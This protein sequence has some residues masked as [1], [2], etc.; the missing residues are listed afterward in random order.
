MDLSQVK[1]LHYLYQRTSADL[2][3]I[4]T[5]ASEPEMR[6]Y[7]ESLVARAYSEIH[8]TRKKPHRLTPFKWFF[9]TFPQTFRRHFRLF[10]LSLVIVL[11]GAAFGGF[12]VGFDPEAKEII[13]PFPH[14]LGDPSDRVAREEGKA[15]DSEEKDIDQRDPL[16]GKKATFSAYL[17]THNTKVSFLLLALGM[18]WGVGTV[19]LLFY[20]GAIL[21]AVTVDYLSAGESEFLLGWL[22]PHGAIE[23]PAF[24]LAGQTGLLLAGALIGW[25]KGI[26][27]KNR[28]RNISNDLVTLIFGVAIML[29]W[30]GLVEAFFSQ[31]HEPL[32]P[33]FLKIGFGMA[34]LLLLAW[35][36]SFS[37]SKYVKQF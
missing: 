20:N 2:G 21:G 36:L 19:I 32:I 4:M 12:A 25:G 3:K 34:E 8:E 6:R 29:I 18:I 10:C 28:L 22:L 31:Y 9:Q 7:L 13:M 16:R 35:F 37:G 27:L 14:L 30:A 26:S 11:V 1:D 24:I 15:S 33:Y 17:M 23:I 5:F